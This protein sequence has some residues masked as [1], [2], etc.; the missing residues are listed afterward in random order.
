V[1]T[2]TLLIGR[3]EQVRLLLTSREA[4]VALSVSERTLWTLTQPRGPI[5]AIRLGGRGA[6]ARALR[7]SV[8]DLRAWIAQQKATAED[9]ATVRGG[10]LRS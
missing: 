9:M 4:A 10:P 6:T 5:P 2:D 3:R 7:Y 1:Q 8:D